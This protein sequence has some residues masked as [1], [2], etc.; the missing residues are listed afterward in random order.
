[1]GLLFGF[2][3]ASILFSFLCSILEAVL[4][5][6]TP[7][8][9]GIQE[10][11]DSHIAA[12]LVRF[13][14]DIDRPLAAILT[15]NTIAHTVGA[16]GVGSQAALIFGE[17]M[18]EIAGVPIISLEALIAGMMTLAI[19]IF[20][21]V[22]PKTIGANKWEA[23][24]PFTIASLKIMLVVLA[25][26]VWTSQYITRHLKK[27]KDKP[28]LSRTDFLAMAKLGT[29]SGVLEESEQTIIHN[30]LRFSKVLVKDV[31]TPRIVVNTASEEITVREF[32]N[33]NSNLPHSRI[34]V[35]REKNDNITGYVLRDD[36]LLNLAETQDHILLKALRRDIVVVHRTVPIPDLLDTFLIKKEHMALVVDEFGGMEGIVTMEDIIETLL[37]LEIVDESDNETDMQA[38]ARSNWERRAKRL[39]IIP[40]TE[41]PETSEDDKSAAS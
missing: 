20:S 34:P 17:S 35:Y 5:S 31:M 3:F 11:T 39:G 15:L 19:L 14:D 37:G 32:Q 7:A 33:V 21:E 12:D 30:L 38:L 41:E 18:L 40:K 36:I 24:T 27:D 10:Q 16:I 22:I 29:E 25:P 8:Y 26:L 28:V 2:F 4:L 13:K 9:V 23:L 6:I 1:M